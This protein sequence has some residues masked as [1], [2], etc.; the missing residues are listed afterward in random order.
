MARRDEK[1]LP[2]LPASTQVQCAADINCK[3][4][5]RLWIRTLNPN[6]RVCVPHYYAALE[7]DRSLARDPVV[8]SKQ[9]A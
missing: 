9:A 7:Q 1:K 4:A 5:G 8:P 2:M 6:E 3:Y